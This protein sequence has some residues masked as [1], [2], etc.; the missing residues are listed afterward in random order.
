MWC[1]CDYFCIDCVRLN[2]SFQSLANALLCF[3]F[4]YTGL[5]LGLC[6]VRGPSLP[7]VF[8]HLVD[9][10]VHACLDSYLLFYIY[11]FIMLLVFFTLFGSRF[12]FGSRVFASLHHQSL[13]DL[14]F[15]LLALTS[16][17][18]LLA[19]ALLFRLYEIPPVAAPTH[20]HHVF[21]GIA[22]D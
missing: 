20:S 8:L 9:W 22:S 18:V 4:V 2:L 11:V 15:R 12:R 13:P 17:P 14:V 5:A 3:G 7:G 6:C 19:P 1:S 16:R 21:R 10:S